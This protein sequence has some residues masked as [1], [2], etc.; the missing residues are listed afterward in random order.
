M[1]IKQIWVV[2]YSHKED[3]LV[4]KISGVSHMALK[5]SMVFPRQW[6]EVNKIICEVILGEVQ[7]HLINIANTIEGLE[8]HFPHHEVMCAMGICY[9]QYWLTNTFKATYPVHIA[10]L[11]I[12]Y[13]TIKKLCIITN[14]ETKDVEWMPPPLDICNLELQ[15]FFFKTTMISNAQAVVS[16]PTTN[17]PMSQFWRKLPSNALILAKLLEFMEVVEIAQVQV[18]NSVMFLKNKLRNWLTTHLDLV[19]RIFAQDFCTLKTS[20]YQGTIDRKAQRVCYGR[21]E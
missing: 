9:T 20:P 10:T 19:V 14:T 17:K 2:C 11:T 6:E 1:V 16:L 13:G 21:E 3:H 15:S 12:F 18:L 4:F 5:R 8:K 7:G